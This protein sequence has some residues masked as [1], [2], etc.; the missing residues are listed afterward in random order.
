MVMSNHSVS[1]IVS[2]YNWPEA[3]N[4]CLISIIAQTVLPAEVII[5]DDGSGTETKKLI[6]KYQ[7]NFPV[8]LIHVWQKDEGF[9]LSRIRN[10]AIA[11]ATGNYI[12]QIDGDLI[13]EPHFIA[14][15]MRFSRPG[16]FISGTRVQMS[17]ALSEK[18]I[19]QKSTVVPLLSKGITNF[20]NGLRFP[21][22]SNFLAE[23]YKAKQITYVRG[24]NMA[25]WKTDLLKVNGYNESI[26]GWGRE[27]SEIAVRLVN[28]GVKKRILKF[29][30]VVFHIYHPE[31]ARKQLTV[32]D[33]ILN[34]S[35]KNSTITCKSGLSLHL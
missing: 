3:L 5:A 4:L 1:L 22:L 33:T 29:G 21:L 24:C 9:Q 28:A 26:V 16:T 34:E 35:I 20:S 10:K 18:M 2:T 31:L 7:E 14:D 32:N 12:I 30:G 19:R 15:H 25:F 23:R 8:P 11:R 27:D 17:S 13:L 6:E